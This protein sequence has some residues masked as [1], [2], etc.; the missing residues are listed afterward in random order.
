MT[1][2]GLIS[3][4]DVAGDQRML[5]LPLADLPPPGL[6]GGGVAFRPWTGLVSIRNLFSFSRTRLASPTMGKIRDTVLADLGGIDIDVDHLGVRSEGR[7]PAGD[8]VVEA[9]AKGDEEIGV[10]Q[11]HVGGVAAVHA[12][13]ADEVGVVGRQRAQAHEGADGRQV[14]GF[15][16]RSQFGGGPRS[17]DPASGVHHRPLCLPD[18]L[19]GAADLAGVAFGVDLVAG[20]M[21]RGNGSVARLAL[22]HVLGDIDEHGTGAAGGGDVESLVD[23]LRQFGQVLDEVV[24]LGAGTGD[25][26]GV[27]FLKRIAADQLGDDLSR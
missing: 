13:H 15:H 5:L 20:Q 22:E 9:H 3:V 25:A 19:G 23:D 6:A 16:Q 21:D 2:C 4:E 7:E 1:C 17:D 24:V 11:P 10:R 12:G 8:T 18:H 27:R 14:S 26:E